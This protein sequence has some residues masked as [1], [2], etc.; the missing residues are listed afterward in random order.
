MTS[1]DWVYA[2]R[3]DT[4]PGVGPQIAFKLL[5]AFGSFSLVFQQLMMELSHVA[6]PQ[7]AKALSESP[8]Q[9]AKQVDQ[10]RQWL[11]QA[12]PAIA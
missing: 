8:A 1:P 12:E 11:S 7:V 5:S 6:S 9:W 10:T 2:L 4:T 3:M